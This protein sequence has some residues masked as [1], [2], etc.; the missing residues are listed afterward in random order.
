MAILDVLDSAGQ[1]QY[2]L[3]REQY[4]RTGEG[5]MVVYSITSRQNFE[6]VMTFQQQI[7]RVKDK[8]YFPM[9]IVGNNCHLENERQVSKQEGEALAR[10]FGCPFIETSASSRINVDNAFYDLVREIRRFQTS[11]KVEELK[12]SQEQAKKL[13]GSKGVVASPSP[14]SLRAFLQRGRRSR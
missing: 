7:L 2:S 13:K 4:M 14:G 11:E 1:E 8:D 6:E 12:E 3:M 5:F 10:S 9:I